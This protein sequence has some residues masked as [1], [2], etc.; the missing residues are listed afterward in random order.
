MRLDNEAPTTLPPARA[1]GQALLVALVWIGGGTVALLALCTFGPA[2]VEYA[3]TA[4][5][6][7]AVLAPLVSIVIAAW[8]VGGLMLILNGISKLMNARTARKYE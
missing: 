2:I 7:L 5:L 4:G 3:S 6:P 1:P 8:D